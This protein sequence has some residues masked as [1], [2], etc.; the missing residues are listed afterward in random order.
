MSDTATQTTLQDMAK[1]KSFAMPF[2]TRALPEHA[3]DHAADSKLAIYAKSSNI[4][5]I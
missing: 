1:N 4:S 3:T 5:H 2:Y